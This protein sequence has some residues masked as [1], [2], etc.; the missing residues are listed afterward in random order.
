MPQPI[1]QRRKLRLSNIEGSLWPIFLFPPALTTPGLPQAVAPWSLQPH[2]HCRSPRPALL[3]PRA[4]G[5]AVLPEGGGWSWAAQEALRTHELPTAQFQFRGVSP[6]KDHHDS[7]P[8]AA[9]YVG[10][11]CMLGT[12][13]R[14]LLGGP[15]LSTSHVL[16]FLPGSR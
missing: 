9:H 1:L 4:S 7:Q 16:S 2:S 15:R 11:G 13:L 12:L 10:F 3:P 14:P 5:E 6:G 8:G